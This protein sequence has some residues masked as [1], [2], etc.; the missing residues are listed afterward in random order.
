[1]GSIVVFKCL[2]GFSLGIR[3]SDYWWWPDGLFL[4]YMTNRSMPKITELDHTR[5]HAGVCLHDVRITVL[6]SLLRA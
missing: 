1:M 6:N 2:C 3:V 4:V 5:N